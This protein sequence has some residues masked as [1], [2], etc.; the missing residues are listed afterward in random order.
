MLSSKLAA[1]VS[2]TFSGDVI[3]I[4]SDIEG[5][6]LSVAWAEGIPEVS[7][8]KSLGGY[9]FDDNSTVL[10]Y[11][12]I[13]EADYSFYVTS[14]KNSGFSI[15][16]E[17][18]LGGNRYTLLEGKNNDLYVSYISSLGMLRVYAENREQNIRWQSSKMRRLHRGRSYG[19]CRS[20]LLALHQTAE[21]HM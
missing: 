3:V 16:G 10:C 4:P 2:G 9:A 13:N 7:A 20:M 19:S 11:D 14:A 15:L 21:C 17:Y 1:A 5:E 18:S 8:G 6:K 12:G